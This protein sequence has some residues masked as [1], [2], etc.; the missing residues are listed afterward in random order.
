MKNY[1]F[2][3]ISLITFFYSQLS[4]A[5]NIYFEKRFGSPGQDNAHSVKQLSDSS[6]FVSGFSDNGVLGGVDIAVIKLDRFGNPL[7]TQYYGDG[8]NNYC[9]YLNMCSDGNLILCGETGTSSNGLDII[10]IKINTNGDT[11]W[12]KIFGTPV[13]ESAKFIEQTADG[14]FILCGFQNDTSNYNDIYIA[15]LDSAG[16]FLWDKNFGG[17]DND[18]ADMVHQLGDGGFIITGD[19]RSFGAGGYDVELIRTDSAG[20]AVWDSTYG[21]SLAN[22]CQGV[23]VTS[24]G[25]FLSYGE[26]EI[27]PGSPY[28]FFL[29][30][31]DTNGSRIWRRTLG[32]TG[33]DAIFSVLETSLHEF[34]CTGYS[35]SYNGNN[36]IDLV[37]F[38]TDPLGNMQWVRSYGDTGID[39][40]YE[41]I[42]ARDSG[43]IA[44]GTSFSTASQ[45]QYYLLHVNDNGLVAAANEISPE[46]IS[47]RVYPNPADK[48]ICF[49]NLFTRPVQGKIIDLSGKTLRNYSIINDRAPCIDTGDL[50]DGFYFLQLSD[51][52]QTIRQKVIICRH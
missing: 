23:L 1:A 21:D 10:V 51:G 9:L 38:K 32:G 13:N 52:Q 36:P 39:L 45:N 37:I 8:E 30:L 11:L 27:Y 33:A 50:Q 31:I 12:T 44:V 49:N 41:I 16:N 3:G 15:K 26:T 46:N 17:T 5:Q 19:T 18:Y 4:E 6:I 2:F 43:F 22:G 14:G 35:S 40:G 34:I 47:F 20:I 42:P 29:D 7:W 24:A 28:D 25:K 48:K